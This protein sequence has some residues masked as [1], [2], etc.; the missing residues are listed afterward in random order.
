MGAHKDR[1]QVSRL[2]I[3]EIGRRRRWSDAEKLRIVEASLAGRR[4][5]SAT[6]REHG[7]SRSLLTTW[8][9]LHREGRL[10]GDVAPSFAPVI[11]AP[12]PAPAAPAVPGAGPRADRVEIVLVSGRRLLVGSGIDPAALTR[13]VRALDRA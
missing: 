4:M 6:A 3:V 9:R 13:L 8:R 11:V 5:V 2:E 7:I 10:G 1:P 12:E